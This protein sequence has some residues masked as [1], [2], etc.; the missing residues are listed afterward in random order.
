[1]TKLV[2]QMIFHHC[3]LTNMEITFAKNYFQGLRITTNQ[4]C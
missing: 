1:L 2:K 4:N 3:S